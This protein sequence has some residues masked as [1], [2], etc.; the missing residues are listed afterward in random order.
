M[1]FRLH[2][3]FISLIAAYGV[4]NT[5]SP[6]WAATLQPFTPELNDNR[7]GVFCICNGSTQTL[8]GNQL[9]APGQDGGGTIS[10]GQLLSS[11]RIIS[12]SWQDSGRVDLG[13]QNYVINVPDA[14]GSGSNSV[15]VYNSAAINAIE[16]NTLPNF[17][18]VNNGQYIN[19]RVAQVSNGTINVDIGQKGAATTASTNGWSMAA[20]QSE[21]F[22]ASG[23]GTMN[24]NSANRISFFGSYTPYTYQLGKWFDNVVSWRGAF[25]VTTL[26]NA[27]TSFNVSNVSSLQSYNNWLIEQLQNGNLAADSYS[28]EFNKALS[29]RSDVIAYVIDAD[30]YYDEVSQPIGERIVLSADGPNARA[31]IGSSGILEVVNASSAAMRASNG[32]T[33]V[34]DGKLASVGSNALELLNG[35]TGINNGVINSGFFNNANGSGVD[36]STVGA[37]GTGVYANGGSRFTNNGVINTAINSTGIRLED[38]SGANNGTL[39]VK[40]KGSTGVAVSGSQA[41]FAQ[42]GRINLYGENTVGVDVRDDARLTISD[43]SSLH[44]YAPNQTGY[45]ATNY[46]HID[47]HGGSYD[48]STPGSALYRLSDGVIFNPVVAADV[49]LSGANTRGIVASGAGSRLYGTTLYGTDSYHVNGEGA[50]A[51]QS[52]EGADVTITNPIELNGNNTIAG[53]GQG[54][55]FA[56]VAPITGNGTNATAFDISDGVIYQSTP[57]GTINL[58]GPNSIGVRIR[59]GGNIFDG[60][61]TNIALGIALD[62][63][64][65]N[66]VYWTDHSGLSAGGIAAVRVGN[67]GGLTINGDTAGPNFY[68]ST[69]NANAGADTILLGKGAASLTA[70]NI[71]LYNSGGG[72]VLNNRAET[73]NISLQDVGM[74][75]DGGTLI[76]SAT[77]FDP[78]GYML[79]TVSGA[80]ATGYVFSKEDGNTTS[81]DLIIPQGYSFFVYGPATGVRANTT[82]RVI[83]NG[84][85]IVNSSDGG[86]AIVTSTASEVINRGTIVSLSLVSPIIDLR[87]GNSV[88][89]NEGNVTA[90]YPETVVVAGG[91]TSDLIALVDGNVVGDVNT[92]NGTDVV[93]LTGGT[94]DGSVTMGT[95]VNN[96]ASIANVSL[97]NTRHI[98]TAGGSGSTLNFSEINA[99]GGSFNN[100]DLARGVNLGAGWSTINFYNTQFTL[101]DNLKLAHSTIN[102]DSGST[103]FVGDQVNPV[104]SGETDDSLV[105]NNAGTLNLTNGSG[106]AG[107]TLTINGDLASAGGKLALRTQGAQSDTLRVNGNVTGTT[108]INDVLSAATLADSNRDGVISANE[109][110]SLVQVAGSASANSFALQR[111]Y[112]AAGAW[113]YGLYSFAPENGNT[114]W[115]YRLA[116][117]YVC[118]DGSLCQPQT[119]G[120]GALRPA[121][122]PQLPS[123]ISAPVGLAYYTLATI[124]DLHQRLGELRQNPDGSAEMFIRYSGSNQKYKT[125]LDTAHYGYDFDL[126]YSAVQ[127]GGNLLRL[128]GEQDSLRGG[129]A[130]TRGNARIRPNA[131]DGYSS[132]DF[133]SDSLTIYGTWQRASGFYLDGALSLDW[134][135][136]DTDIA[137]QKEVA[138]LKG[139]GWTASLES[140][141]P[142]Q[143]ANGIRLEPQAQLLHLHLKLDD[144]TDDDQT[145][146]SYDD[147]DQT[148]GRV[149]ARLARTWNDSGSGQYTPYLRTNYYRGWG[150][151]AKVDVG[152]S[153]SE[154]S[155]NFNSG[156]FGQMWD[157]GIGG[158]AAFTNNVSLYAEANYRKE[159]DGNGVQGWNYNAGVRWVF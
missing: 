100:D 10:I 136:G 126:D 102:V 101:T 159:I 69:I 1:M 97:A 26:D 78:N 119:A 39:N 92:G 51:V 30:E 158:N 138:K 83:A 84:N 67:N 71:G 9:F 6:V 16:T 149:G 155:D 147:Y 117:N 48:V 137:R 41:N 75:T 151:T 3:L 35:S 55:F 94:I 2:P 54:G 132:T 82:G 40:G 118:K 106:A 34:I 53:T 58:T 152:A 38:A 60:S 12:Y 89:I 15:Q 62:T 74:N 156:K 103:L 95:G 148:I 31:T 130:Y 87:G 131:A 65:G 146:V 111:G 121:V 96:V 116:N 43:A 128:D 91:A 23:S 19:A 72:S 81:N 145:Q 8:S 86:S 105:V 57:R 153:N 98:T 110:V 144:F 127:F 109:G 33:A 85:I 122:I 139:K 68:Y 63:A 93:E 77:S 90:P 124:G 140:G 32:A 59:G 115:D 22:T 42:N 107:N 37:G 46:A 14:N 120:S 66:T 25:S 28:S 134:H 64:E 133:D 80:G 52:S 36:A 79:G 5:A 70:S 129:L 7:A 61:S 11:G 88:F 143:L 18:N 150:G 99:R 114:T 20:K 49:T 4:F 125:N 29:L 44:F 123:Y 112:V 56:N 157:A 21:L 47:S 27:T 73:S 154:V 13:A 45:Q 24:W 142:F 135:R 104:L 108:F 141:Y 17:Y 76:R 113:Q 50:I